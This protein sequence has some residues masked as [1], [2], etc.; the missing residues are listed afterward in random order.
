MFL[1]TLL[2]IAGAVYFWHQAKKA[3]EELE[4]KENPLMKYNYSYRLRQFQ[5]E[6]YHKGDISRQYERKAEPT[7]TTEGKDDS[8]PSKQPEHVEKQAEQS[9]KPEQS[10]QPKDSNPAL[11]FVLEVDDSTIFFDPSSGELV[12]WTDI[13][14]PTNEEIYNSGIQAGFLAK[15]EKVK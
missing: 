9:Q 13:T 5:P 4:A 11:D 10:D 3:K 6:G 1:I 7:P 2:C 12:N 8:T 14:K 15:L